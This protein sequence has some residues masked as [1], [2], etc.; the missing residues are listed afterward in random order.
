MAALDLEAADWLP[1][2]GDSL[3]SLQRNKVMCDVIIQTEA[4]DNI[5]AHLVLLAASKSF[6]I[7]TLY[8]VN[9]YVHT[10]NISP[11]HDFAYFQHI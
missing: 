3:Y 7:C 4:G 2:L 5:P 9:F 6:I 11:I 10:Y 1:L 8:H